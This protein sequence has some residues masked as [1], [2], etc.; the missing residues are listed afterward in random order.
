MSRRGSL[1]FLAAA[2]LIAGIVFF[3]VECPPRRPV[4][5]SVPEREL[6][7]RLREFLSGPA[8]GGASIHF[9]QVGGR[10]WH[11]RIDLSG[12]RYAALEPRLEEAIRAVPARLFRKEQEQRDGSDRFLWDVR[13]GPENN[14]SKAILL[15]VC[16]DRKAPPKPREDAAAGPIAAIIIDDIGYNMDVVRALGALGRPLTL[17][18]LPSCPHT[19]EAAQAA[20]ELGLEVMLHLPLESLRHSVARA[21]GTIDTDMNKSDI[22]KSVAGFLD[23]LPTARGVNNHAGS[24]ATEDPAVMKSV[25]DVLKSRGL[26]FIDSRTSRRTV[27]YD[28]ARSLGVPAAERR[29]FLD[30][31]PGAG[32]VRSRLQEL[33]RVARK[34][35]MAVAI[36]HARMETVEALRTDLPLADREGVRLVFVSEIV[37]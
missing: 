5:P 9:F 21:P 28:A 25:L 13:Q 24:K 11:L 27:A 23:Q 17:A 32:T 34:T 1:F 33:F 16:P 37:R 29:V 35:G 7:P 22:E 26:Y 30:E 6:G 3:L 2:L 36:G 20:G 19:R 10:E 18:I 15:F 12:E 31:P 8:T 14:P 4:P